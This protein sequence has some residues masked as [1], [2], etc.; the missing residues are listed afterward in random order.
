MEVWGGWALL[1]VGVRL[2]ESVYKVGLVLFTEV[3][4]GAGAPLISSRRRRRHK[5]SFQ[6]C[7]SW[8]DKSVVMVHCTSK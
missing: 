1:V 6:C 8:T 2:T 3:G 5:V 4:D 7:S